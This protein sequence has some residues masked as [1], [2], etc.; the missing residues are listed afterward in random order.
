MSDPYAWIEQSLNT[1][2][3]ARW[4]RRVLAIDGMAGPVVQVNGRRLVNFASNDYLGL[5]GHPQIVEGAIAAIRL[6]GTGSTGSRLLSGHRVLHSELEGAIARLKKTEDA[7]V[8]AAATW[9]I[10]ERFRLW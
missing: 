5:A 6:Y 8:L 3:Q 2:H 9:L 7:I 1:I 10:L 4:H